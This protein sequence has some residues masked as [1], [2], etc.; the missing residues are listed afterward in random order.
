[1]QP[2]L[3]VNENFLGGD[4]RVRAE[5][6][7]DQELASEAQRWARCDAFQ[8]GQPGRASQTRWPGSFSWKCGKSCDRRRWEN[9]FWAKEGIAEER[10]SDRN[11]QVRQ[12]N[13]EQLGWGTVFVAGKEVEGDKTRKFCW[14]RLRRNGKEASKGVLTQ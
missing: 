6:G 5:V 13:R 3:L 9:T 12:G 8:Q 4:V 11:T 1:M 14:H 7:G 2:R 10:P